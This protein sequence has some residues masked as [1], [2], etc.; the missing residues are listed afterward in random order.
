MENDSP[1]SPNTTADNTQAISENDTSDDNS[2]LNRDKPLDDGPPPDVDNETC[3]YV[4]HMKVYDSPASPDTT[5]GN[6]QAM[7][8]NK[9]SD[10]N[11]DLN[12]VAKINDSNSDLNNVVK[13]SE[14]S[15]GNSDLNNVT[16]IND[17]N[18][19]L[20]NIV[21]ISETITETQIG[22]CTECANLN[23]I[24]L[25]ARARTVMQWVEESRNYKFKPLTLDENET[26]PEMPQLVSAMK[27]NEKY[28]ED[29]YDAM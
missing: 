20:N 28:T 14:T 19:D 13:I 2:D 21:E 18:S 23:K 15:D 6:T 5:P 25:G 24:C 8:V 12:S 27:I 7:S 10:D 4:G 16:K 9:T 22:F 11:S 26:D 1:K 3:S 17:G 29:I